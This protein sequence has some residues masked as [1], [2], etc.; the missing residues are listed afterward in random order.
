VGEGGNLQPV[1]AELKSQKFKGI[2]TVA[3]APGGGE[4]EINRFVNLVNTLSDV[5]TKVVA[6]T[7]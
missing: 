7:K 3:A 2:I 4:D 1:L 5:V 6:D